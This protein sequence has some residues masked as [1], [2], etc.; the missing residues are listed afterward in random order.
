MPFFRI[1]RFI[2]ATLYLGIVAKAPH[3]RVV[4]PAVRTIRF[5]LY[6]RAPRR[7]CLIIVIGRNALPSVES[8]RGSLY[9]LLIGCSSAKLYVLPVNKKEK[10]RIRDSAN[11]DVKSR[12]RW[13]CVAERHDCFGSYRTFLSR[14]RDKFPE[15]RR[16]D[17]EREAF[18]YIIACSD[19]DLR[20]LAAVSFRLHY[21][22]YIVP[23]NTELAKLQFSY[24]TDV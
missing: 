1:S 16:N 10:L 23:N 18:V 8:R 22:W 17:Y 4:H 9:R 14:T 2:S 20:K 24:F 15:Q 13:K 7:R 3:R 21:P 12:D 5:I 6:R 19:D 11:E